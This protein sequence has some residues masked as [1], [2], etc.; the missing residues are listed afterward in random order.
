MLIRSICLFMLSS[1]NDLNMSILNFSCLFLSNEEYSHIFSCMTIVVEMFPNRLFCAV[2]FFLSF[3]FIFFLIF[4]FDFFV[5]FLLFCLFL[6]GGWGG[7]KNGTMV[8]WSLILLLTTIIWR[9]ATRR[10]EVEI[11]VSGFSMENELKSII[12]FLYVITYQGMILIDYDI[13]DLQ[14]TLPRFFDYTFTF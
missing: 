10:L 1:L 4:R 8:I 13:V 11:R 5:L 2:S 3:L 7:L 6:L 14:N 12:L 9:M